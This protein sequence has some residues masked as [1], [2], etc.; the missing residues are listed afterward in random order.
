VLLRQIIRD[1]LARRETN[2]VSPNRLA[3]NYELR[4]IREAVNQRSGIISDNLLAEGRQERDQA[5]GNYI[6]GTSDLNS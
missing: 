2:A 4:L 6:G 5:L 1:W 3:A